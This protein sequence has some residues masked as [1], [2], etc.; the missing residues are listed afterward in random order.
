MATFLSLT[1]DVIARLRETQVA[2]IASSPYSTLISKYVNDVKRQ[3][4]NAWN[5]EAFISTLTLTTVA[6]THEYVLTGSGTR[7]KSISVNNVTNFGVLVNM[8]LAYLQHQRQLTSDASGIPM[9]YAWSGSNGT[10]SKVTLFPTPNGVASI[11]FNMYIPQVDLSADGDIL[12]APDD[13]VVAGAYARALVERGE[14]GGLTSGE[15]YGLYK[16]ILG[17]LI[18]IEAT[19][20]AD[21]NEWI[22]V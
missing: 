19:R 17:D 12:L 10:D 4:E 22:A 2:S 1:N 3:V 18:A 13:A 6:N 8:P 20:S 21:A 7:H 14:D 16:G 15:A 5:W 9:Y 11:K